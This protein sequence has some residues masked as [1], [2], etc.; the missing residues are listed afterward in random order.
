MYDLLTST[1]AFKL[2]PSDTNA[3]ADFIKCDDI[4]VHLAAKGNVVESVEDPLM[5]FNY[6]YCN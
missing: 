2:N 4:I 1:V 3:I 5:N 6:N